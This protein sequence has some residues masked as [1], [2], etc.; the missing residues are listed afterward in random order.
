MLRRSSP[1]NAETGVGQASSPAFL[2][3]RLQAGTL[4]CKVTREYWRNAGG[5]AG[6][7]NAMEVG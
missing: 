4:P 1:P 5:E 2:P 7:P 3:C 6:P